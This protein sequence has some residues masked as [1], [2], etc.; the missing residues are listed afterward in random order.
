[1]QETDS[2]SVLQRL[3]GCIKSRVEGPHCQSLL[4]AALRNIVTGTRTSTLK[5]A[6]AVRHIIPT[7]QI[8]LGEAAHV[9]GLHRLHTVKVFTNE[10]EDF[11]P[12][13][14]TEALQCMKFI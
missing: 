4:I 6:A 9:S 2:N 13:L 7:F 12:S 11:L 5:A 8:Y 10:D 14:S 1:M 3:V